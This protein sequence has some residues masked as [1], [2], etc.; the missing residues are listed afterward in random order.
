MAA[1]KERSGG[2][3]AGAPGAQ[4]KKGGPAPKGARLGPV[5]LTMEEVEERL[6]IEKELRENVG[7]I[8]LPCY[9]ISVYPAETAWN[10]WIK[11]WK[12]AIGGVKPDE[13]DRWLPSGAGISCF[14][15]YISRRDPDSFEAG[16]YWYALEHLYFCDVC[17][18]YNRYTTMAV[19]KKLYQ[20]QREWE[21]RR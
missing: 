12:D 17:R 15:F 2:A 10:G 18:L 13:V 8:D 20:I 7:I 3:L 4:K 16:S 5:F 9:K 1:V 11:G 14:S 6:E 21:E 19:Y